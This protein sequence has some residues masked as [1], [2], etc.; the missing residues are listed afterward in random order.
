[1]R[2]KDDNGHVMD[3]SRIE[4]R[5][6]IQSALEE[7][8]DT[9]L[10]DPWEM[11]TKLG[12]NLSLSNTPSEITAIPYFFRKHVLMHRHLDTQRGFLELLPQMFDEARPSSLLHK[13]T[14][15][16]A[17]GAMSNAYKSPV[18]RCEARKNYGRALQE[19]GAA[20][21]NPSMATS[22]EVLMSILLFSLYEQITLNLMQKTQWTSHIHGAVTLVKLRGKDQFQ[23]PRSAHL[24]RAVRN[25]MLTAAIQRRATIEDYPDERGWRIDEDYSLNT[26]NRL[27]VIT[28]DLPNLKCWAAEVLAR[29]MNPE[30]VMDMISVI[31]QAQD[32]DRRLE[33][34]LHSLPE[35]WHHEIRRVVTEHPSN[36]MMSTM[37]PGPVYTY[38]DLGVANVM[39]ECR[40]SRVLCQSLIMQCCEAIPEPSMSES[41]NRAYTR[42]V[43]VTKQ[44]VNDF[45]STLPF[46]LGFDYY[47]RAGAHPEDEK[48]T[49]ATGAFFAVWPLFVLK[50][51]A[52][53]PELQRKWMLG[54]LIYIGVGYGLNENKVKNYINCRPKIAAPPVYC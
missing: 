16:L 49:I 40:V 27:T 38:E 29:P 37:W 41:L 2:F 42:A 6:L 13:A 1:V 17:L 52:C 47:T 7:R 23:S 50:K 28:L 15:A 45:C 33:L 25:L 34:W 54:R 8:T 18:M 12:M 14:Y 35:V 9:F 20:I 46:L 43:Y 32:L 26:A 22:D 48:A 30:T 53:I 44:M 31:D 11:E 4:V 39:N 5:K 21:Q 24:F 10:T 19:L 51:I 36:V 3:V